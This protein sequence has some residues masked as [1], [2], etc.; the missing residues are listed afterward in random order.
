MIQQTFRELLPPFLFRMV[1][2]LYNINYSSKNEL[3][4][5]MIKYLNYDHGYYIEL[6][7]YDGIAQSNTYLLERKFKWKGLLIEPSPNKY[8]ECISNRNADNHIVC[9]ACVSFNYKEEFVKIKYSGFFTAPVNVETDLKDINAHAATGAQYLSKNEKVFEFGAKAVTLNQLLKEAGA[10][11]I[12]DFLSLDVEGGE[13][14]VLKGIDY[15]VYKF[16]YMLIECRNFE[17][18]NNYLQSQ[19]YVFKEQMSRHDYLF[20]PKTV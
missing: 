15:S 9:A 20:I 14:E 17:K 6:G 16:K 18:V 8:F 5:Q 3:Y 4:K 19:G 2:R 7:A 11:L 10:P 12:I 1:K 13:M